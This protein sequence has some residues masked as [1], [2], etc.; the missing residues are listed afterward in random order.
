MSKSLKETG[1]SYDQILHA[2]AIMDKTLD[3]SKKNP[4]KLDRKRKV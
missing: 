2:Q 1:P 4:V 3:Q